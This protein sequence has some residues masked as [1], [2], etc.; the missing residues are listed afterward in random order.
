MISLQQ[1]NNRTTDRV[2][3]S[4][5]KQ[6]TNISDV[7]KL[8]VKLFKAKIKL[9]AQKS[10]IVNTNFDN[11]SKKGF[12]KL[13]IKTLCQMKSLNLNFRSLKLSLKS[14]NLSLKSFNLSLKYR[15]LTNPLSVAISQYIKLGVQNLI[16]HAGFKQNLAPLRSRAILSETESDWYFR[17]FGSEPFFGTAMF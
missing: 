13:K 6:S 5:L 12:F 16:W 8:K 4:V 15:S 2:D 17:H 10:L 7:F 9:L 1:Q 14:L 3:R 11:I